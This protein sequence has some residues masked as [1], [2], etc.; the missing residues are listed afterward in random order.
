LSQ[1]KIDLKFTPEGKDFS[2]F[3]ADAPL[4]LQGPFDNL[5]SGTNVGQALVPLATPIENPRSTARRTDKNWADKALQKD[6]S[7]VLKEEPSDLFLNVNIQI[8]CLSL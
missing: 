3:S 6:V 5:S 8:Q 7:A 1:K 2:F 4:H